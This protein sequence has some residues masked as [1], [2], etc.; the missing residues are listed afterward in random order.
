MS[1]L[2]N[3]SLVDK[4]KQNNRDNS[5]EFINPK[6]ALKELSKQLQNS[7]DVV[8]KAC[9]IAN[10]YRRQTNLR[11]IETMRTHLAAYYVA[12]RKLGE[13]RSKRQ[14]ERSYRNIAQGYNNPDHPQ[15]SSQKI[16]KTAKR[17]MKSLNMERQFSKPS[18]YL[19]YWEKMLEFDQE[20][21]EYLEGIIS[22]IESMIDY[23]GYSPL[24]LSGSVVW[25]VKGHEYSA[26][27]IADY[28]VS[29]DTT[30]RRNGRDIFH[31]VHQC[32]IDPDFKS[33]NPYNQLATEVKN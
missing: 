10:E 6:N 27:E 22:E 33:E 15:F 30:I 4:Y 19:S 8:E 5:K 3:S 17:I 12:S 9:T 26:E 7:L 16:G 28:A 1:A 2:S 21:L 25:L 18:D 13:A 14:I 11:G 24:P 31:D 32:D 20:E 29:T 23:N